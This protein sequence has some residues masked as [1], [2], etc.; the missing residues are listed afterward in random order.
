MPVQMLVTNQ[1]LLIHYMMGD[2]VICNAFIYY[3]FLEL[4]VNFFYRHI[5]QV[6]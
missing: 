1:I 6:E 2:I 5:L 4:Y 3:V